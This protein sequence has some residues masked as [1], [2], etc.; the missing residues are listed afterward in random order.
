MEKQCLWYKEQINMLIDGIISN[1]D[2]KK[3]QI[4]MLTCTECQR[5]QKDMI[6]LKKELSSI[7]LTLPKHFSKQVMNKIA[8]QKKQKIVKFNKF[9][10][11]SASAIA[12]CLVL[13]VGFSLLNGNFLSMK[14]N[15]LAEGARENIIAPTSEEALLNDDAYK[16]FTSG[17]AIQEDSAVNQPISIEECDELYYDYLY[18]NKLIPKEE[19]ENLLIKT[20]NITDIVNSDNCIIFTTTYDNYLIIINEIELI[21]VENNKTTKDKVTIKIISNGE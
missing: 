2:N 4:H 5:Y 21:I 12:A 8:Y 7:S 17:N 20:Y 15:D 9:I 1:K 10:K 11:Y 3:L 18:S 14:S 6:S 13:V 16:S 19:L